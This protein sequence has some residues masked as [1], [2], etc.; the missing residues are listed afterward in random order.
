MWNAKVF[1]IGGVSLIWK[2]VQ[3]ERYTSS[4]VFETWGVNLL[5]AHKCQDREHLCTRAVNRVHL[6]SAN[7][8]TQSFNTDVR[9]GHSFHMLQ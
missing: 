3:P 4:P 2:N 8:A 6:I 7:R 5:A 9:F 1:V